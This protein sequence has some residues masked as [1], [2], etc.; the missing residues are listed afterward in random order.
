MVVGEA[1]RGVAVAAEV[2]S[3][4]VLVPNAFVNCCITSKDL[5][6]RYWGANLRDQR[7]RRGAANWPVLFFFFYQKPSK[8]I[9][10]FLQATDQKNP[11]ISKSL[12]ISPCASLIHVPESSALSMISSFQPVTDCA[13]D[14]TLILLTRS[15]EFHSTIKY[16]TTPAPCLSG[17][18]KSPLC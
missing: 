1:S 4:H 17:T 3:C 9:P 10:S 14:P 8:L 18:N 6:V 12:L 5:E 13:P 2:V 11:Q 16:P 15:Q 7:S